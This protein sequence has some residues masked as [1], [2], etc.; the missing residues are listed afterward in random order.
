MYIYCNVDVK[1]IFTVV[2]LSLII[3]CGH[4][5]SGSWVTFGAQISDEVGSFTLFTCLGKRIVF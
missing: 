3:D 1:L 4:M 2:I 5:V